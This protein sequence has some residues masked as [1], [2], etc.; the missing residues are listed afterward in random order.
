MREIEHFLFCGSIGDPIYATEFLEIINYIKRNSQIRVSIVTNGSYKK[1]DWWHQLA[2]LLDYND[3][4]TFSVDGW[5]ND[6][7]NQ[8]RVNSNFDSILE[9]IRTVRQAS[10]CQIRW[11]TIYFSFNQHNI[12]RI[13]EVARSVGCNTFQ[14]VKSS[15][16]DGRYLTGTVDVMKPADELVAETAVYETAVEQLN[17]SAYIPIVPAVSSHP[18]AWA[19]C[20]N[21]KKDMFVGIDGLVVPCPWFDN[22][23]HQNSFVLENQDRLSIRHRSFFEIINDSELWNKLTDSFELDPLP[24]CKLKCKNDTR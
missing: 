3:M 1:P 19:K 23:Y 6:S 17:Q 8:Y 15:K 10:A 2:Q 11:S 24:I 12:N 18:H 9:G 22:T 5:D 16:F 20:L 7:N 21:Y 4:I 14:T 13:R